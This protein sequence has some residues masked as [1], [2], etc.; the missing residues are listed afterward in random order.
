MP[1]NQIIT[2]LAFVLT[3]FIMVPVVRQMYDTVGSV[4]N[5]KDIFSE[6][7]VKEPLRCQYEG[8]GAAP[9]FLVETRAGQRPRTLHGPRRK[10]GI[11]RR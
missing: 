4:T 3:I 1:P 11:Q 6:A 10:A 5:S 2:G 8:Q 7:S 9:S